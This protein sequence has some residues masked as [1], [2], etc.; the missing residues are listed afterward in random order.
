MKS[1]I[2]LFSL[3]AVAFM[4][5]A[6]ST[7]ARFSSASSGQTGASLNYRYVSVTDVAGAD[8]IAPAPFAFTTYYRVSLLDS[9][10][11]KQPVISRCYAGDQ[12][13]LIASGTSGDKLKFSGS[14]WQTAGTAT[15][16]S[17]L[18]AVITLVFDGA[19]WVEASRVVQ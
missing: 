4:A 6:Q 9:F 16:S 5:D 7:S 8:S 17:G 13:V 12:I 2:F 3:L 19:K 18:R 14:N 15:L 11:M 1:L 10:T